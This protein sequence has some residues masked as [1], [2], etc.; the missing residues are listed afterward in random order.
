MSSWIFEMSPKSLIIVPIKEAKKRER[1]MTRQVTT[2]AEIGVAIL[3][4]KVVTSQSWKRQG[5]ESPL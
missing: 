3:P 5:I 1:K 4:A 2:E